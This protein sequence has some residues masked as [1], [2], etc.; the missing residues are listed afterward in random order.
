MEL[1]FRGCNRDGL[2]LYAQDRSERE[3]FA[4][5][6]L[7][8]QLLV[9]Y[10]TSAGNVSQVSLHELSACILSCMPPSPPPLLPHPTSPNHHTQVGSQGDQILSGVW[11]TVEL[12]GLNQGGTNLSLLING[13]GVQ[14][15]SSRFPGVSFNNLNGPLY[16]GGH[17]S[18]ATVR[19]SGY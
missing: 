9:E 5:G 10:H 19:V 17:P 13:Q 6:L 11:Y 7:D 4:I 16:I 12:V 1:R 15:S 3:Y 18:L 2:L 8:G 14:L